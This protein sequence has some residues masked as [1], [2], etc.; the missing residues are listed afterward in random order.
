MKPFVVRSVNG[1]SVRLTEERWRHIVVRHPEIEP[2][3]DRVLE[4]VE[5][6]DFV[7]RGLHG[8][9]KAA[10]LSIELPMGPRY[11]VVVYGEVDARDGFIITARL[12]S[13]VSNLIKGGVIWRRK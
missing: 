9:L 4:T 12:G 11:F 2:Y 8:E 7:A 13:G 1:V 6:P 5:D 3:R 10:R